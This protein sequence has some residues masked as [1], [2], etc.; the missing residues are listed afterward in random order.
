V[1]TA[2]RQHRRRVIEIAIN[3][4]ARLNPEGLPI[5]RIEQIQPETTE[6]AMA[7]CGRAKAGECSFSAAVAIPGQ[8]PFPSLG[9]VIA[10]QR[11]RVEGGPAILL[12]MYGS[13]PVPTSSTLPLRISRG[14]ETAIRPLYGVNC[15]FVSGVPGP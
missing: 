5:C 4:S 10:F 8:A 13:E 7:A 12:H 6:A 1:L 9:E 11:G 2:N 15:K 14:N 3:R